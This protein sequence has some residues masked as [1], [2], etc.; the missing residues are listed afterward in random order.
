MS[1]RKPTIL[2]CTLFKSVRSLFGDCIASF[3]RKGPLAET[4]HNIEI[5]PLQ[6]Y[7]IDEIRLMAARIKELETRIEELTCGAVSDV[8]SEA[9][10][11]DLSEAETSSTNQKA[12]S[13]GDDT[14]ESSESW[15][16]IHDS[17]IAS[18]GSEE[19][20]CPDETTNHKVVS[21]AVAI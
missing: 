3:R 15:C 2:K 14:S 11:G 4:D 10:S 5:P 18:G 6:S 16:S 8:S 1:D 9:S 19:E 17:D 7:Y 20:T 12:V 13:E 21:G